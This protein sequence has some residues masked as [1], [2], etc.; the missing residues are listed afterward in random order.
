MLP[1]T[2]HVYHMSLIQALK[3]QKNANLLDHLPVG[4]EK[5]VFTLLLVG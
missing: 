5:L 3:K 4:G 1:Q 2:K